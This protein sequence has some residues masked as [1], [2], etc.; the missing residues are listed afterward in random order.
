VTRLAAAAV[1][2]AL[3]LAAC[4]GGDDDSGTTPRVTSTPSTPA[5]DTGPKAKAPE[6]P[7]TS[8]STSTSPEQQPGGAGDET[9]AHFDASL[10]GRGGRI[11]PREVQV[12]P[13]ISVR[14]R[15]RSADGQLYQLRINGKTL[16]AQGGKTAE[17]TLPGL[18]AGRSYTLEQPQGGA[19]VR[20]T[21]NAEPGP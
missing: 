1:A 18:R 9:P 16:Q 6:T 5:T 4:G 21:A 19:P 2:A 15:L 20:I 17:L 8:P 13:F 10:T 14:V 7:A 11:T 3:A 12:G